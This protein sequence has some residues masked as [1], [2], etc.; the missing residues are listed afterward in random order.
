MRREIGLVGLTLAA[1]GCPFL[2]TGGV[3]C[4]DIFVFGLTVNVSNENGN[5]ISG[6]ALTLTEGNLSETMQETFPGQYAGA[7]ERAGTYTLTVEAAGFTPLTLD[8]ITV[9]A[10]ICH[11]IPVARDITLQTSSAP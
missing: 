2:G 3:I 9:D 4:T 1:S 11:V 7:G 8:N 6:A 5:P 10:D